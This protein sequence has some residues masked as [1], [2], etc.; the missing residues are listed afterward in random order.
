MSLGVVRGEG[1]QPQ[2]GRGVCWR[3]VVPRLGG[4][5]DAAERLVFCETPRGFGSPRVGGLVAVSAGGF[6]CRVG[7][8]GGFLGRGGAVR[9]RNQVEV[10]IIVLSG[11]DLLSEFSCRWQAWCCCPLRAGTSLVS[12]VSRG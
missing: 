12:H 9:L 2:L 7:T 8:G 6:L 11:R 1:V 4:G 3:A 10:W 5:A